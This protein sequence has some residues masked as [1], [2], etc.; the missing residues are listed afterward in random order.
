MSVRNA[1]LPCEGNAHGNTFNKI[2]KAVPVTA[3][4]HLPGNKLLSFASKQKL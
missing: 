3:F 4:F 2:Y 1:A